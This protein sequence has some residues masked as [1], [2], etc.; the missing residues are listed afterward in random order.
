MLCAPFVSR[1][2]LPAA[3]DNHDEVSRI[4][5]AGIGDHDEDSRIR[6]AGPDVFFPVFWMLLE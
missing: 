6:F 5:F 4:Q 2:A 1:Y 3:I